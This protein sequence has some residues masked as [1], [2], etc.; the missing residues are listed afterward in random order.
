MKILIII[1]AR[2]QFIKAVSFSRYLK[3]SPDIQEIMF[4]TGQHYDNNMND[5]FFSELDIPKPDYNLGV[6]SD[7]H[8][9]QTA[10]MMIG[11]ERSEAISK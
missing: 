11:C 6:G 4:H 7:T 9:R 10:K 2:P 3:N 1:G 8:A 5:N